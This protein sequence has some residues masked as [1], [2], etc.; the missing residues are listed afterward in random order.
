MRSYSA[1]TLLILGVGCAVIVPFL[2]FGEAVA[3]WSEAHFAG[4]GAEIALG[5]SG[6]ALLASDPILP[7]PSSIVAT[8]LGAKLGFWSAVMSIWAG[9]TAGA[10]LGII[11]GRGGAYVAPRPPARIEAWMKQNGLAAVLICRP[12]P[13]LAEVSLVIAGVTGIQ[14]KRIIGWLCAAN[15]ALAILYSGSGALEGM[16]PIPGLAITLGAVGIPAAF[17]AAA[18]LVSESEIKE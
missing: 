18:L 15:L 14:L 16:S 6:A 9:L 12:V 10:A 4:P 3:S 7:I 11:I 13:V 17:A 8:L 1:F 2:L 5:V